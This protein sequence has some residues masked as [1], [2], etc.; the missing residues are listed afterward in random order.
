MASLR[1][2]ETAILQRLSLL[3]SGA[4]GAFRSVGGLA[5]RSAARVVEH[6]RHQRKP[7]VLVRYGVRKRTSTGLSV[8][9]EFYVAVE[10]LRGAEEARLGAD[11]VVGMHALLDL[12]RENLDGTRLPCGVRLGFVN[13]AAVADDGRLLV[14]QQTYEVE[15]GG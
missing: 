9:W 5:G 2:I 10:G 3:R 4:A 12:M 11:G 7:A 6:L 14:F 1:D 13:E 8:Q 15:D